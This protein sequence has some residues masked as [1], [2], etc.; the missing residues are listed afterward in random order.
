MTLWPT[1]I[2]IGFDILFRDM[3]S[4]APTSQPSAKDRRAYF[5]VNAVLPI[6]IQAETDTTEGEFIEKSVNISG[7]GIGV[8]VNVVYNPNEV[9]SFTLILP[10]Q[11]IFKAYAEVLRLVPIPHH[12]DTYRLHARFV[13]MTTQNRELLIRHILRFQR[14]RL[15]KHY[16]A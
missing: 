13:R 16:S 5:R 3:P 11:V 4:D 6:S 10:D 15:E 9:L 12:V 14:D 7:G 8:T 2:S 1:V